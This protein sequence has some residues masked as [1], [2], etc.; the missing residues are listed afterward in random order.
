MRAIRENLGKIHLYAGD[1]KGKTTASVG[2]AVR[3]NGS[4]LKVLFVQFLK[5]GDSAELKQLEKLGI[6]VI[7]GQPIKSFV[8]QMT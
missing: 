5:S 6:T 2:L 7:S 8:F 4:G 3:A 1:G